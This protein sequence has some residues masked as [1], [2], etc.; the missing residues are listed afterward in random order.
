MMRG[1]WVFYIVGRPEIALSLSERMKAF[2]WTTS[3]EQLL[4]WVWLLIGACHAEMGNLPMAIDAHAA[5]LSNAK[6]RAD[7]HQ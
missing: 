7:E 3:Q 2:A 5:S 4:G 6:K 1:A